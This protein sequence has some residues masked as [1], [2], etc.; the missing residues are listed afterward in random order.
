[1]LETFLAVHGKR[2]KRGYGSI[3]NPVSTVNMCYAS[4]YGDDMALQMAYLCTAPNLL[5][6]GGITSGFDVFVDVLVL[7]ET[8]MLFVR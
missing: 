4:V 6:N 3:Y 1:M 5:Q 2:S 7:H 8:C